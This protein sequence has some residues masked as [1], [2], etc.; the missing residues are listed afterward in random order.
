MQ[1]L[2]YFV[3]IQTMTTDNNDTACEK[4]AVTEKTPGSGMFNHHLSLTN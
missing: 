1:V 3:S 2:E 4:L